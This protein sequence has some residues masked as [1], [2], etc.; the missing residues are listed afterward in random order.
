MRRRAAGLALA[1]LCHLVTAG[2]VRAGCS[3]GEVEL[4]GEWGS[5]RFAVEIADDPAERSQGLMFREAL[6]R[7]AGMLF[8]YERAGPAS[9]WMRNTLIPLDMIFADD[10]G[11]VRHVHSRAIPGDETAIHGGDDIKVVLEINGGLAGAMGIVPGSELRHPALGPGAA[12]PCE[13]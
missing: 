10:R 12:W 9:F 7:S 13:P 2:A 6:A 4:R 5:A 3:E 11:V 8:V 1:V